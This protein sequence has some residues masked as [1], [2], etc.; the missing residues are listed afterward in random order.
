MASPS[1]SETIAAAL[2]SVKDVLAP[3]DLNGIG[4]LLAAPSAALAFWSLHIGLEPLQQKALAITLFMVINWIIEP[5]DHGLTALVGIYLFWS[6]QVAKFPVAFSG[7]TNSTTWFLFSSLLMAEA[8]ARTGIAKRIGFLLMSKVGSSPTQLLFGLLVLSI[9][10]TFF[11]PSGMGRIAIIAPVTAGILQASGV[12]TRSNLARGYFAVLTAFAGFSDVMI[13]SGATTMMTH[14]ILREHAGIEVLWSQWLLAFL[15]LVIGMVVVSVILS[16]WLYPDDSHDLSAGKQYFKQE[17]SRIGPWTQAEKRSFILLT[18]AVAL[19]ATDFLHR[20]NPAVIGLGVGLLLSLPK[21][22]VLDS[23]A[24]KQSNFLVIIFSAGAVSMGNVL[25]E[26]NTLPLV[27]ERLIDWM[28]PLLGSSISYTLTLYFGGFLYHFI[29]A[30]RQS[31]LITSLP[32]LLV[33]A[34]SQGLD[35]L[36]LA[37]LWTIG[38]GGGLFIYQSGVYVVGYSYGYFRAKDFFK[39]GVALT[40]VQGA[41][42]VLLVQFYWPLIGL[43]W[44]H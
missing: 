23:K 18:I 14:A 7:F 38:G 28:Q 37:L 44:L 21:I 5:Y 13:L 27:T 6:L 3:V 25:L 10:L 1:S 34:K 33:F 4:R 8:A 35:P 22:G 24:I 31:M 43:K 9:A 16:R 15:P 29:F 32:V 11:I 12:N 36:P 19:W 30:N 39:I 26:T 17:L 20:T 2:G 41:L 40:V 42:L